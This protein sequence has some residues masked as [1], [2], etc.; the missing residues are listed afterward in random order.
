MSGLRDELQDA[1][2]Q[3]KRQLAEVALFR[4]EEQRTAFLDKE[5]SLDRLRSD[6]QRVRADLEESHRQERDAAQEK[7]GEG[8]ERLF[9]QRLH[10]RGHLHS[11]AIPSIALANQHFLPRIT[12]ALF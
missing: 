1:Q 11:S 3:H 9:E 8:V 2:A 7:V 12:H 6:M 4:E 5:A 10:E